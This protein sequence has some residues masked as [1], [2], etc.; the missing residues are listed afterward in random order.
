MRHTGAFIILGLLACSKPVD[1]IDVE[2]CTITV[3]ETWPTQNATTAHYRQDIEFV[4]SESAPDAVVVTDIPG[5]QWSRDNDTIIG[6]SLIH[7]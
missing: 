1:T 6:L 3:Q 7:I 4:L 2:T 5:V